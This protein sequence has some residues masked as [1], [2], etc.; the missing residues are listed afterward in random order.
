MLVPWQ[1]HIDTV[2]TEVFT[3]LTAL[4]S[5]RPAVAAA[6]P[7]PDAQPPANANVGAVPTDGV[8]VIA[9]NGTP[10]MDTPIA[11]PT[12]GTWTVHGTATT[13]PAKASGPSP[14]VCKMAADTLGR[15]SPA[16]YDV[17]V[18]CLVHSHSRL[19]PLVALL[20]RNDSLM[21][22]TTSRSALYTELAR[23]LRGLARDGRL[24]GV[25]DTGC[26]VRTALR[27][28]AGKDGADAR[29]GRKRKAASALGV[30][31]WV[32]VVLRVSVSV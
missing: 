29:G 13:S 4:V 26:P 30:Y 2:I 24:C 31:V 9:T 27:D 7:H 15:P 25:V 28:V 12:Y 6:T 32:C 22:I 18:Q 21:D 20:L 10:P 23:L 17:V 8:P 3:E 16:M 11:T 19:Q 5:T 1:T 14:P